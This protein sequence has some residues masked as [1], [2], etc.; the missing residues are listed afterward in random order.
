MLMSDV[1]TT[2]VSLDDTA[3]TGRVAEAVPKVL[4]VAIGA[5]SEGSR[6]GAFDLKRR[7]QPL[8][9]IAYCKVWCT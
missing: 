4:A 6:A 5:G 1:R 3:G 9:N 2:V 7:P 8:S